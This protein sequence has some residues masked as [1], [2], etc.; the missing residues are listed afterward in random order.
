MEGFSDGFYDAQYA[1]PPHSTQPTDDN[2]ANVMS[3]PTSGS[4]SAGSYPYLPPGT[5]FI[6]P[7]Q[8]TDLSYPQHPSY[9]PQSAPMG[10]DY[11]P[12]MAGDSMPMGMDQSASFTYDPAVFPSQSHPLDSQSMSLAPA[13]Y[14]TLPANPQASSMYWGI[15][16]TPPQQPVGNRP[17]PTSSRQPPQ[18]LQAPPQPGYPHRYIQPKEAPKKGAFDAGGVET[19]YTSIYSSSGFDIMGVLAQV[20]SRP[21]P[22]INIGAVDLSCA[23]VLCDITKEDHPIVYVSEPFER[24]TG[25][26]KDE[27]LG[28]NCRFLQGPD[29]VV[30]KGMQRTFVDEQTA[31]RLRST[32]EERTEIQASLINYRKGGQPFMNLITMIPIR[33]NSADYRFYVG[34]Q[35]D[36]VEKPDAVTRRNPDGTYIVNYQRSQLPSY[37][38]PP[39]EIYRVRPDLMPRFSPAEVSLI[40]DNLGGPNSTTYRTYLDRVLAD[41]TADVIHVL[42]FEGEFLYLSPS[43]RHVLE[44]DSAELI[45]KTLSTICHPSDIGP[46]IRDLRACT[47]ADPITVLYRIRRKHRGYVWFESRGAWHIG[48][49]G[50]QHMVLVGRPRSVYCL[51]QVTKIRQRGGLAENDLWAKLSRS[52]IILFISSKARPVLGRP[53]DELIGKGIQ[54]LVDL[55]RE[56]QQA[57][58]TARTGRETSFTHRIRHKKGHML[59]VQTTFFPGDTREGVR[60]SFLVAQLSFPRSSPQST[61]PTGE[62]SSSTLVDTTS[63]GSEDCALVQRSSSRLPTGNDYVPTVRTRRPLFPELQPTRGSSWQVELRDLEKQ[64]RGLADELQRILTRR[65]KRKRKLTSTLVEKVCAMCQTRKTP[66][67]RRGPSG[68]RDL[69]NSCGLRWAKQVKQVRTGR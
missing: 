69:C 59:P 44:Y 19:Q 60:P 57:L 32:I 68:N 36:L 26:T 43:C 58:E 2:H 38:V 25:Y 52:G 61:P 1:L 31:F 53:A 50:R 64:N 11:D 13:G 65:K 67:W 35:V 14:S 16:P 6:V 54:E 37:V 41:N 23:F 7:S 42:S 10:F 49:R 33:W 18:E 29:G 12:L 21:N 55:R 30:E 15:E 8:P 27:I 39:E 62:E 22:K 24:L 5:P 66:E 56:A 4:M 63:S 47:T 40:L 28:Q 17:P 46:V 48:E 20:V 3:Y 34:F 45:G 51:D 9:P